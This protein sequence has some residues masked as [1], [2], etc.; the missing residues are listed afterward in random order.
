[1]ARRVTHKCCL[2]SINVRIVSGRRLA[3]RNEMVSRP[4]E[5]I[6]STA[7]A[8]PAVLILNVCN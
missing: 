2:T 8:E 1:M 5:N 3:L 7:T 4:P 6:L